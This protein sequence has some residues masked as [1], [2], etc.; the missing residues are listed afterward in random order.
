M[1][2]AFFLARLASTYELLEWYLGI[3]RFESALFVLKTPWS[4]AGAP[5]KTQ[6]TEG[7]AH[8]WYARGAFK[9][10]LDWL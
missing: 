3:K 5:S 4:W 8:F 7:D 2:L 9:G 6:Q 10:F 1:L